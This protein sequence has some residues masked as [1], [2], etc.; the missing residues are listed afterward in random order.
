[1][2]GRLPPALAAVAI[3]LSVTASP[4]QAAVFAQFAPVSS[5]ADFS[6]I[7]GAPDTEGSFISI[8]N[9]S[10]TTAQAVA[11]SFSFITPSLSAL[12]FLPANFVLDAAV[13][14]PSPAVNNADGSFTQP[15]IHGTFSFTYTGPTQTIGAI[16]LTQNL[17]NLLSGVFSGA[18]VR[19]IGGSGSANLAVTLGTLSYASDIAAI[20]GLRPGAEEFAFNLLS[21]KAQFVAQGGKAMTGITANGGGNFS[22]QFVPEPAAWGLMIAGFGM[23]GALIR[24]RR[25]AFP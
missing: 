11:T 15:N 4:V 12:A 6:W 23:A 7:R 24:R 17:T 22:G 10:D 21:A 14:T 16:T 13:T 3:G 20:A 25:A 5:A 1:M 9:A 18:Y 8:V 19:G 2:P